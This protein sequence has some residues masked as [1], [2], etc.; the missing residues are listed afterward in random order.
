LRR[1]IGY[2]AR[3]NHR[4]VGK[5]NEQL[6]LGVVA[7]EADNIIRDHLFCGEV[8]AVEVGE[9]IAPEMG[10]S[11]D[12]IG[13][14]IEGVGAWMVVVRQKRVLFRGQGRARANFS[15]QLG[16]R[17]EGELQE[18][19]AQSAAEPFAARGAGEP[20]EQLR[21]GDFLALPLIEERLLGGGEIGPAECDAGATIL[22]GRD[23]VPGRFTF[24]V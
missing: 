4:V 8:R 7:H 19:G 3:I 16:R 20:V 13:K 23:D 6:H 9:V 12:P 24:G 17:S 15:E 18:I 5:K 1:E 2:F 10:R 14:I 21:A 22:Q 11:R